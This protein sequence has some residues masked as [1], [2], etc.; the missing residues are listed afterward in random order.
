MN[1][2]YSI[3]TARCG[4]F[5]NE[6]KT[7]WIKEGGKYSSLSLSLSVF[8][9][10]QWRLIPY[11]AAVYVLNQ[12]FNSFFLSFL[13]LQMGQMSRTNSVRQVRRAR[14]E[15]P[16]GTEENDFRSSA[17]TLMCSSLDSSVVC[18]PCILMCAVYTLS[19]LC[20]RDHCLF[21]CGKS[22]QCFHGDKCF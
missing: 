5:C 1:M 14:A 17:L 10:Q 15:R 4:F 6:R 12:F 21:V 18:C 16:K 20:V 2:Y 11:L 3:S 8:V 22:T 19:K 7:V 9:W 13:E